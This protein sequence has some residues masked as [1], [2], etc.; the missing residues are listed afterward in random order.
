MVVGHVDD[1][2][3]PLEEAR[4]GRSGFQGQLNLA[5][6]QWGGGGGVEVPSSEEV[7]ILHL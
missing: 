3:V 7:S 1:V 2:V 4:L 5:Q 6:S